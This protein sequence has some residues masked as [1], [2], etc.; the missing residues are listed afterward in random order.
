MNECVDMYENE[1][2]LRKCYAA[3]YPIW[4]SGN[5]TCSLPGA[6]VKSDRQHQVSYTSSQPAFKISPDYIFLVKSK[7]QL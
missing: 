5:I 7:N 6:T 2:F 4:V 1:M 3:C